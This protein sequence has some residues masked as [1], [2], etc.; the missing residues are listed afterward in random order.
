M[1]VVVDSR[2]HVTKPILVLLVC[3]LILAEMAGCSGQRLVYDRYDVRIGIETDPSVSRAKQPVANAHPTQLTT[4]E[5]KSLLGVLHITAW[6]GTI[7]GIFAQP[8][9]IP[10]LTDAQL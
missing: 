9:P 10:L 5:I 8:Q 1:R 4:Q 3:C 6:S 2:L 7:I